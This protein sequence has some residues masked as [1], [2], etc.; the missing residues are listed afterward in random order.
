MIDIP[1]ISDEQLERAIPARLRARL[2]RGD[3]S[4]GEET[5][6]LH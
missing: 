2:M 5:P 4:P 1:E 3:V 6:A